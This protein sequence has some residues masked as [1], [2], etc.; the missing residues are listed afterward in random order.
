MD[1]AAIFLQQEAQKFYDNP[2]GQRILE[3]HKNDL[4]VREWK[5]KEYDW[6]YP[7]N[8]QTI[9]FLVGKDYKSY[10]TVIGG[11]TFYLTADYHSNLDFVNV[12][13]SFYRKE[14]KNDRVYLNVTTG[15][16]TCSLL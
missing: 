9:I 8:F 13:D 3:E 11:Y 1:D 6:Q 4:Q 12:N 14:Y 16:T 7:Y 10:H 2:D 5:I 15:Y